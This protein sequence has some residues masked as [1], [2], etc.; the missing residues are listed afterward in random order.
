M[1]PWQAPLNKAP[2]KGGKEEK[3]RDPK[4]VTKATNYVPKPP[5]SQAAY[6]FYKKKLEK[7]KKHIKKKEA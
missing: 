2:S 6:N 1:K 3:E 4:W 7:K 5:P